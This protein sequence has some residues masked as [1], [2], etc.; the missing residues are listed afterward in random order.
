MKA[1]AGAISLGLGIINAED[2][3]SLHRGSMEYF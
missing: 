2:G 3:K 1:M